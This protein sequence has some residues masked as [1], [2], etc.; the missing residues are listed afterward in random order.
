MISALINE[1]NKV[2][3]KNEI[4][5]VLNKEKDFYVFKNLFNDTSDF[6]NLCQELTLLKN[7]KYSLLTPNGF[8]TPYPYSS[9]RKDLDIKSQYEKYVKSNIA[10]KENLKISNFSNAYDDFFQNSLKIQNLKLPSFPLLNSFGFRTLYYGKD[11]ID[12]H[13]ENAFI[14]QLD[15]KFVNEL[16]ENIDLENTIS[17]FFILDKHEEEN[18]DLSLYN[19]DWNEAKIELNK[20][21]YE[22]RHD[23]DGTMFTNRNIRKPKIK[24]I[25]LNIGDLIIFRA[26][27]LWHSVNHVNQKNRVSIGSFISTDKNKN[28]VYWV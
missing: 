20:T 24:N 17:I 14:N 26:A 18:C 2:K 13:C 25:Q 9:I 12:I 4:L 28:L 23:K 1:T 7:E 10:I 3:L 11:G 16:Y 5:K 27:Q 21:S 22:E 6:K 19:I 15:N 8:F